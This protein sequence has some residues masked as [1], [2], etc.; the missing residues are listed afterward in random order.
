M[1]TLSDSSRLTELWERLNEMDKTYSLRSDVS[2]EAFIN[3]K[4]ELEARANSDPSV[5]NIAAI[6]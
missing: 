4:N 5:W 6:Y 2:E 3:F 1:K